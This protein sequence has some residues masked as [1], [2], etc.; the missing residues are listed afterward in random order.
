MTVTYNSSA[1]LGD[2][3]ESVKA[4]ES[5]PPPVTVADNL[6]ADVDETRSI[7]SSFGAIVLSLGRNLGYGGAINA[8]VRSVP[9]S[10][11]F[12]L[13][14]N[15]DVLVHP[16][17]ISALQ[18]VLRAN[19]GAAAVGPRILNSDGSTYP[20]ARRIPSLRTGVGHALFS[21]IW[22]SNPWTRSY[23]AENET[24][25]GVRPVGWL[26]GACLLIRRS[27]FDE[28]GGFDQAF[29]MY[30]EDVDL[31]YRLGRAGWL[32]LYVPASVVT[33]TG[34]HSTSTDALRMIAAH[35]ESAY[36]FLS[37]KYRSWYLA[38]VRWALRGS[39]SVRS[40]WATRR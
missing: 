4:S 11:D 13:V 33:H 21:R 38:P 39:L 27:A 24:G 5:S 32:N 16:G 12:V 17:A 7:A 9:L 30:F 1:A 37:R 34:A 2:F 23:R 29:F 40:W 19:P 26:S 22:P 3:L 20:S 6:S 8:A 36:L 35:H 10:Y 25:T 18:D 15:P 28:I 14:S 31:G